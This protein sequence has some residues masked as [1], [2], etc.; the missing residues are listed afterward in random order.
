MTSNAL[1]LT[2]GL[3]QLERR[4]DHPDAVQLLR[5]FYDEQVGRYGFAESV[6]LDPLTYSPPSGI[7]L[8]AYAGTRPVGCGGCRWYDQLN[9]VAEIKKTYLDPSVRGHGLGRRLLD[10]LESAA[11]S[12]G[13][14]QIILET[15]VRNDAALKLFTTSGYSPIPRY[16]PGRSPQIN[17][18]FAKTLQPATEAWRATGR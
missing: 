16:V 5:A 2:S 14:G 9:R 12:W 6:D 10:Q 18:A 17:R 11:V 7:F 13:A 1:D 8:V 15:G 4:V 3:T